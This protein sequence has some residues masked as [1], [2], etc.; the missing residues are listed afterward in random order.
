MRPRSTT[1]SGPPHGTV[2]RGHPR[3]SSLFWHI[4]RYPR[5]PAFPIICHHA[6]CQRLLSSP[7]RMPG[8][9]LARI[10]HDMPCTDMMLLSSVAALALAP[11]RVGCGSA[12]SLVFLLDTAPKVRSALQGLGRAMPGRC[13]CAGSEAGSAYN[14]G[15]A[16]QG[17]VTHTALV[18][19][20]ARPSQA[21]WDCRANDCQGDAA[22][23]LT[24]I[25]RAR[26]WR[27]HA[28]VAGHEKRTSIHH[29]R[30]KN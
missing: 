20:S 27:R 1:S 10:P 9:M 11:S 17:G 19:H 29:K 15:L 23:P 24:F 22:S 7:L 18:M 13:P 14:G 25:M 26:G 5:L 6:F 30:G 4:H 2:R 28:A 3:T 16:K 12:W 8:C 21:A